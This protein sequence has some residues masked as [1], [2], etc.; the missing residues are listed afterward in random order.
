MKLDCLW[1]GPSWHPAFATVH[2][3]QKA[4][5]KSNAACIP[6]ARGKPKWWEELDSIHGKAFLDDVQLAV[7]SS[8]AK[9]HLVAQCLSLS[10]ARA[11]VAK[12]RRSNTTSVCQAVPGAGTILF[13]KNRRRKGNSQETVIKAALQTP[14]QVT[15]C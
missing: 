10:S 14:L 13:Q 5:E 11:R 1:L 7:Q 4:C 9:A 15:G 2:A 8:V 3:A 6:R 12:I